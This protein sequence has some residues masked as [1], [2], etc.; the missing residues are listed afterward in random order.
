MNAKEQAY[1]RAQEKVSGQKKTRQKVEPI[2][3]ELAPLE[4]RLSAEENRLAGELTTAVQTAVKRRKVVLDNFV[5][6][7]TPLFDGTLN[8]AILENAFQDVVEPSREVTGNTLD[9]F[10][11]NLSSF[12]GSELLTGSESKQIEGSNL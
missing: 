10:C 7:S 3:S 2:S 8:A 5:A 12:I 1:A 4:S 11:S 6:A 9:N